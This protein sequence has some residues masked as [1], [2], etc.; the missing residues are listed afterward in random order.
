MGNRGSKSITVLQSPTTYKTV[1]VKEQ[2]VD[3]SWR[4]N[5]LLR[6]RCILISFERNR[7]VNVLSKGQ[8]ILKRCFTTGISNIPSSLPTS[9]ESRAINP[10]FVT[11]FTDAEG[12]FIIQVRKRGNYW[13]CE[14][15]FVIALHEKDRM[16]LEQIQRYFGGEGSILKHG[17]DS[18]QYVVGSLEQI[19]K[20]I[21][22][23]FDNYPLISKKCA[24]YL[25]F[26]E[27]VNIM[28]ANKQASLDITREEFIAKIVAIRAS[29]NL[30]LSPELKSSFPNVI[31]VPRPNV[32]DITIRDPHWVAGFTSGEG[33]FLIK[34]SV[35]KMTKV[36][37]SVQLLFQITQ[38]ERDELLMESLV[39]YFGCGVLVK[40]SKN[41]GTRVYY[42]VTKFSDIRDI[43]IPLFQKYSILGVKVHDFEDWCKVC[44]ILVT[45]GHLTKEGL[46]NIL[47][48][49]AGTNKGRHE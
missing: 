44:N 40:D 24:D 13:S 49:K 1:I 42:R 38:H 36:G 34:T 45:K 32:E 43:I 22:P 35:T 47:K 14:A 26:K 18:C 7:V 46:D 37:H 48:I 4:S 29:L 20:E 33:C 39:T 2:R 27:A 6:L 9:V 3:G 17:K 19:T 31:A 15:R 21:L 12:C 8:I 41:N 23:H 25:L 10:W 5:S 30:G 28:F 16:L 11:G